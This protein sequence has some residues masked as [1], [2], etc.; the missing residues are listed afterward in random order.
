MYT[1]PEGYKDVAQ[2]TERVETIYMSLGISIDNTAADD[3]DS[4][5]GDA[6]PMSNTMELTDATYEID[7]YLATFEGFGIPTAT[8]MT[9]PPIATDNAI[10]VGWWSEGISDSEGAIDASLAIALSASH[11]SALTI[12]TDGPNITEGSIVFTLAGVDTEVD[13]D[14]H[15]G[16]AVA[17][18]DYTYDSI[19]INITQI[20]GAYQHVRITE[21]EFGDSVTIGTNTLA[22]QI[23]YID[24]IDPIQ[25]G[26]PM[27]ELDFDLINVNGE[28]DEDNPNTL[29][30]RLA[31]GNPIHLSYTLLGNGKRFTIPM[32]RF[33]IAEK[34]TTGNCVTVISYDPRWYLTQMYNAWSIRTSEDLGTTIHSLLSSLEIAHTIDESVYEVYPTVD[35]DFTD[36]S[37]VLDDLH[38]V[39]QAFGLTILPNRAGTIIIDTDFSSESY[40]LIPPTIQFSWPEAS[41]MNRYNYV[42]V[43]YGSGLHKITDLRSTPNVAR[44]VLTIS[45]KLVVTE[46]QAAEITARIIGRLY[47]KAMSI[48]WASDPII[49]LYDQ[50]EVYSMW[51]LNQ[52]PA[53]YRVIK[54]EITYNGMLKEETTLIQ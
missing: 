14:C 28:Y 47:Q 51:T 21:I 22:N 38:L 46:A 10:R 15:E 9:V 19:T 42:D 1:A 30:G 18:G 25:Q 49:D 23:T 11:V 29:F 54:R 13:L 45:N 20:A 33:L 2:S 44:V 12:Y 7:S 8:S 27:R 31:I 5:T 35:C 48:E 43:A 26:L 36:E 17:S 52:T 34:R 4:Y 6:L 39:A 24:E 3:I 32:G 37:T 40:G 41:Q 16:Y 50:V 53:Q